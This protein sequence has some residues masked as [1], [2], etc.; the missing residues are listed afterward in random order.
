MKAFHGDSKMKEFLVAQAVIHREQDQYIQ[1]EYAKQNGKFRGCSMGCCAEDLMRLTGKQIEHSS[2]EQQA[3]ILDV[4]VF[5][6]KLQ[7]LFFERLPDGEYQQ[8]TERLFEA[9]P[10]GADLS[11]ALPMFLLKVL[12]GLPEQKDKDV[13]KA[14][15]GSR[16]VI[17]EWVNTGE[18]NKDAAAEAAAEA[19]RAAGAAAGAAADAARA[20]R[21]AAVVADAA[22]AAWAADAADAAV[23]ADAAGAAAW[24][25]DAADA[26][27]VADAADAA[28]AARAAAEVA[29]WLRLSNDFLDCVRA[30]K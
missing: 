26:A 21:A 24:A 13:A 28:W 18:P 27:V 15:K 7:E 8:W 29:A 9:V 12:D 2:H 25:A 11:M 30:C 5:F 4:P 20:A 19:A 10:V 6:V 16:A 23:V 17:Q 14:I 1:G 22:D 3:E